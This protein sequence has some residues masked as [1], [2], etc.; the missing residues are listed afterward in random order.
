MVDDK[1][2]K[3]HIRKMFL[4]HTTLKTKLLLIFDALKSNDRAF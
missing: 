3:L 4:L 1:N 2:I